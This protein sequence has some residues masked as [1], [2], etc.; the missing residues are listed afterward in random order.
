MKK[1]LLLLATFILLLVLGFFFEERRQ[2]I[3]QVETRT[4]FFL[5]DSKIK[6]A[7]KINLPSIGLIKKNGKWLVESSSYP[8]DEQVIESLREDIEGIKFLE[9]LDVSDDLRKSFF[10][11]QNHKITIENMSEK[12][13]LRL[14][15][16]NQVTGLFY[17]EFGKDL[18]LVEIDAPAKFVYQDEIHKKKMK[19]IELKDLIVAS[20]A[21]VLK[22]GL[23]HL[24]NF[25]L[26]EKIEFSP[27][28]N[29]SFTVGKEGI[30]EPLP[31][32]GIKVFADVF[33]DIENLSDEI[34]IQNIFSNEGLGESIAKVTFGR[35][36]ESPLELELYKN[37]QGEMGYFLSINSV[38]NKIFQVD[39]SKLQLFFLGHQ[40]FWNKKI[41]FEENLS[42][43]RDVE[44]IVKDSNN[45]KEA[46]FK[47]D[48]LKKFKIKALDKNVVYEE[49]YLNLL[50]NILFA[51]TEFQQAREVGS[52]ADLNLEGKNYFAITL[53]ILEREF[54]F[55]F[56][57]KRI[58][59]IDTKNEV[60]LRY[61]YD[62]GEFRPSKFED[63]VKGKN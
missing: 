21:Q 56:F 44:F 23:A 40:N 27:I 33:K 32:K 22:K 28:M 36:N 50:F 31:P 7:T 58:F 2:L 8:V 46:K 49:K 3:E 34:S 12:I 10:E 37:H 17:L 47:I 42:E 54:K 11:F 16:L 60:Y 14:G 24:I 57:E 38:P 26:V 43:L 35:T 59:L 6:N 63:F 55:Y 13:L 45:K 30:I 20:E 19:Y 62:L 4:K 41:D 15:D 1:N 61:E 51:T 9:K 18:Y 53:E 5:L 25:S 29:R 52:F 39:D 48:N